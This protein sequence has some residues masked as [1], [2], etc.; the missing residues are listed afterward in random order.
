MCVGALT[1]GIAA[2]N[3]K[4]IDEIFQPLGMNVTLSCPGRSGPEHRSILGVYVRS[5][6]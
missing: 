3:I 6:A 5:N 1:A 2:C 4:L